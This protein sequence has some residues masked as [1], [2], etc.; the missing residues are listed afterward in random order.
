M[1]IVWVGD[2]GALVGPDY[3]SRFAESL[4]KHQFRAGVQIVNRGQFNLIGYCFHYNVLWK[5]CIQ[6]PLLHN[7]F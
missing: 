1:N 5:L 4:G 7:H 3:K 6:M 2:V